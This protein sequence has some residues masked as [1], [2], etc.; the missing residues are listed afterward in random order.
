MQDSGRGFDADALDHAFQPFNHLTGSDPGA[1]LGL[2]IV[3][4]IAHAHEGSTSAENLP[5]GG[6]R[7]TLVVRAPLMPAARPDPAYRPA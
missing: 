3:G 7:V 1:G 6:A 5:A 4:A 2:A